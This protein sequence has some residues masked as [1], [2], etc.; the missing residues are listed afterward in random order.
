MEGGRFGLPCLLPFS[1]GACLVCF[2]DRAP[3]LGPGI[4]KFILVVVVFSI[5]IGGC[6]CPLLAFCFLSERGLSLW[7]T[8]VVGDATALCKR[9]SI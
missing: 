8:S 5:L 4:I 9:H 2:S 3:E 7:C 6:T 1:G